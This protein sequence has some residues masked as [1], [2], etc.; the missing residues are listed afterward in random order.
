MAYRKIYFR[1]DT[2]ENWINNNPKLDYGEVAIED[3]QNGDMKLKAGNGDNNWNDLPYLLTIQD[4]YQ[5][6][7][8]NF[9]N[10]LQSVD[11]DLANQLQSEIDN[12]EDEIQTLNDLISSL[13]GTVETTTE[14]LNAAITNNAQAIETEATNRAAAVNN[15]KEYLDT[16]DQNYYNTAVSESTTAVQTE[17]TNRENAIT[18]F[19]DLFKSENE[20]YVFKEYNNETETSDGSFIKPFNTIN[21]A[22]QSPHGTYTKIHLNTGD[23]YTDGTVDLTRQQYILLETTGTVGVYGASI[24]EVQIDDWTNNLGFIGINFTEPLTLQAEFTYITFQNCKVAGMIINPAT[25]N[26]M[27]TIQFINCEID[28]NVILQG[29]HHIEITF[30]NCI[31]LK[32]NP[33][34]VINENPNSYI[35]CDNGLD[36][37]LIAFNGINTIKNTYCEVDEN[38]EDYLTEKEIELEGDRT[39]NEYPVIALGGDLELT[40]GTTI[41]YVEPDN[42]EGTGFLRPVYI[43]DNVIV[44]LADFYFTRHESYISTSSYF[45]ETG[46]NTLQIKDDIEYNNITKQIPIEPFQTQGYIGNLKATLFGIDASLGERIKKVY[47]DENRTSTYLTESDG[48]GI[49]EYNKL[50]DILSFTGLNSDGTNST[51]GDFIENYIKYKTTKDGHTANIGIRTYQT[52]G[53][54]Y[55]YRQGETPSQE[56]GVYIFDENK[57]IVRKDQLPVIDSSDTGIINTNGNWKFGWN[58]TWSNSIL[59]IKDKS[60]N[61]IVNADIG[62]LV[63]SGITSI[64]VV[65][66]PPNKDEG[67]YLEFVTAG[68]T[69]YVNTNE[70]SQFSGDNQSIEISS[71]GIISLKIASGSPVTKSSNGID[72]SL[73]TASAKGTVKSSNTQ[74]NVAVNADGTMTVNGLATQITNINTAINEKAPNNHASTTT[75]Y[76]VATTANYGHAKASSANPADIG[77]TALGTD[78]GVF[79]RADHSHKLTGSFSITILGVTTSF[80][81]SSAKSVSIPVGVESIKTGSVTVPVSVNNRTIELAAGNNI[82]LTPDASNQKITITAVAASQATI[83]TLNT[84]NSAAQSVSSSESFSEAVSLHKVSKTGSYNDLLNTPTIPNVP[85]WALQTSKPAYTATEVGAVPSGQGIP[86]GGTTG[87]VLAK[88]SGTNYAAQW[89]TPESGSGG[90]SFSIEKQGAA[91]SAANA[92]ATPQDGNQT[93]V[94]LGLDQTWVFNSETERVNNWS[95]VPVGARVIV[96]DSNINIEGS[97][98]AEIFTATLTAGTNQIGGTL[99]RIGRLVQFSI[100]T[101]AT[102][103]KSYS[104]SGIALGTIPSGYRPVSEVWGYHPYSTAYA[105]NANYAT[106]RIRILNTGAITGVA[107]ANVS[108]A[109]NFATRITMTWITGDDE[110]TA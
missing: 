42:P 101:N 18:A 37:T 106:T 40:S 96:A 11:S 12:R 107:G 57:S 54:L 61:V 73:A 76:G 20:L 10:Q 85:S 32:D 52:I 46:L 102:S 15:L 88:S 48:S 38:A 55:L 94:S 78:N 109:A 93:G 21:E 56:D 16:Q 65:E 23:D 90:V 108:V 9:I 4:S 66:N 51:Q 62:G 79:A 26:D 22:L 89:V 29:E 31:F 64:D 24:G 3:L 41:E 91:P 17:T 69:Y 87:Q 95:K 33:C 68:G 59:Q 50:T 39:P 27:G 58:A 103:A 45:K 75:T 43:G 99:T 92:Y 1:R 63:S 44:N 70:F 19:K 35:D 83:G 5:V 100:T 71:D 98:T 84:N 8:D 82:T 49:T 2:T 81:G 67:I 25:M 86:S 30:T 80:D 74:N 13:S 36:L 60:N 97:S 7:I 14:N 28:G 110:P 47:N 6:Y 34:M 72:I 104:T 105:T 77:T 53:N